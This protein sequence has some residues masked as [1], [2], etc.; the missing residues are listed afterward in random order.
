MKIKRL[1]W[2]IR[3]EIKK[4]DKQGLLPESLKIAHP[5]TAIKKHKSYK[6]T[7]DRL[8]GRTANKYVSEQGIQHWYCPDRGE[9]CEQ[10]S[11]GGPDT[12]PTKAECEAQTLCVAPNKPPKAPRK[13][14]GFHGLNEQFY[15]SQL[16]S[17]CPEGTVYFGQI[18]YEDTYYYGFG[19]DYAEAPCWGCQG[20]G[21]SGPVDGAYSQPPGTPEAY[22]NQYANSNS[23]Q[24]CV[25]NI[26]TDFNEDGSWNSDNV[27]NYWQTAYPGGFTQVCCTGSIGLPPVSPSGSEG[28]VCDNFENG[29]QAATG[30]SITTYEFCVKCGT[31]SWDPFGQEVTQYCECCVEGTPYEPEG[32]GIPSGMNLT[33]LVPNKGPFTPI[34]KPKTGVNKNQRIK[35]RSKYIRE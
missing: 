14:K 29:M 6:N 7:L 15:G 3:E 11:S 17:T 12:Y 27:S 1:R 30:M 16:P 4:L 25:D 34:E 24:H 33:S 10:R 5:T 35:T 23:H 28:S 26:L 31:N 19:G 20:T 32:Q 8:P 21:L 2:K 9:E 22:A 13:D 18:S